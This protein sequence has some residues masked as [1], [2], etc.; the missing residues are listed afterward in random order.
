MTNTP[1]SV[2]ILKEI[3]WRGYWFTQRN[4]FLILEFRQEKGKRLTWVGPEIIFCFGITPEI[5]QKQPPDV[6]DEV[7]QVALVPLTQI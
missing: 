1:L 4:G 5:K 2:F 6:S 3:A 7:D